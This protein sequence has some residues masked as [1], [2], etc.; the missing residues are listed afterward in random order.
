MKCV[1]R[2][3]RIPGAR[4]SDPVW[5]GKTLKD[6]GAKLFYLQYASW[7]G[8]GI[9]IEI[10]NQTLWLFS[11]QQHCKTRMQTSLHPATLQTRALIVLQVQAA[12]LLTEKH[13]VGR[14]LSC[15]S[16]PLGKAREKTK[17]REAI[18]HTGE[19]GSK[20]LILGFGF[21]LCS[22]GDTDVKMESPVQFPCQQGRVL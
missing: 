4:G 2:H 20:Q 5:A 19:E 10:Q 1:Q 6:L 7:R 21:C 3:H 8:I 11:L 12:A 14:Q 13:L 22:P 15:L 17:S 16:L 9:K 18:G